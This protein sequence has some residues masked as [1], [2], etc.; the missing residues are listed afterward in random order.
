MIRFLLGVFIGFWRGILFKN[1]STSLE[2]LLGK[3]QDY[4][5]LGSLIT[6]YT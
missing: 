6:A 1:K 5:N 3:I 4:F 2:M